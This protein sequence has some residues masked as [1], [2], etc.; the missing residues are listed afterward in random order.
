MR[1]FENPQEFHSD[2]TKLQIIVENSDSVNSYSFVL[3][4]SLHL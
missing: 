1:L 4:L 3:I 2:A